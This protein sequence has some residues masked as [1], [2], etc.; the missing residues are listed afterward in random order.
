M[1]QHGMDSVIYKISEAGVPLA[2]FAADTVT[3]DGVYDGTGVNGLYSSY[4]QFVALDSFDDEADMV[5]GVGER[6]YRHPS[7]QP[8]S[9]QPSC[10]A[11]PALSGYFSGNLTFPMAGGMT[12]TVANDKGNM[13]SYVH[14]SQHRISHSPALV[15]PFSRCSCPPLH[16]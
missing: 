3:F 7:H 1:A 5:A 11:P 9:H 16:S 12:T 8:L 10:D 4:S 6:L 15:Q 2:V 13:K 14:R